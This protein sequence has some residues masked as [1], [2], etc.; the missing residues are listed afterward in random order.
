MKFITTN[1]AR[2]KGHHTYSFPLQIH[3]NF[4]GMI[5]KTIYQSCRGM[6]L[7]FGEDVARAMEN[8]CPIV[9]LEST[10]ITHGM[11]FPDNMDTAL[12]V[13]NIIRCKGAVPATIMIL[14]GRIK[15][16]ASQ[17]E[18]EKLALACHKNMKVSRRDISYA[19]A[20]KLNG[21]TT[22]SSTIF[23]A[24]QAKIPV[25]ATGGIGGVHHQVENSMDISAD[26]REIGRTPVVVVCSGIKAI[27][28]I[29]KTLEYL[30]RF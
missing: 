11:P 26:L 4:I 30:V 22:V 23:I 28:D 27:L 7:T 8:G 25:V 17:S 5:K 24:K 1:S 13:E 3:Q 2:A 15:V 6:F 21:G 16:G 19:I 14:D 20:K 18:I 10:I 29:P 9:A 12:E